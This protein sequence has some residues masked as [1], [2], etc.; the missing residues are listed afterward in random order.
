LTATVQ[1]LVAAVDATGVDMAERTRRGFSASLTICP[2]DHAEKE[3]D[4]D[5]CEA[6]LMSSEEGRRPE[7]VRHVLEQGF[8]PSAN[9]A[10]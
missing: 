4:D 2:R 6:N 9:S 10:R 5:E 7:E 1:R 8:S 3:E